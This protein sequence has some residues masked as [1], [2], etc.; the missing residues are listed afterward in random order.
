MSLSG[1]ASILPPHALPSEL[2]LLDKVVYLVIAIAAYLLWRAWKFSLKP[3][4]YPK[5]PRD[6]PYWI[7]YLGHVRTFVTNGQKLFRDGAEYLGPDLEPF[8]LTLAGNKLYVFTSAEDVS[9]AY[10]RIDSFTFDKAVADLTATFGVSH[11]GLAKAYEKPK[12]TGHDSMTI[13]GYSNVK[14]K[15]LAHLNSDY[16]KLQL[17]PG[18]QYDQLAHR[19]SILLNDWVT[20]EHLR[21]PMIQAASTKGYKISAY[22]WSQHVLLNVA[23]R[24]MYGD[25]L[26]DA[27]N[28]KLWYKM[29]GSKPTKDA[30]ERLVQTFEKY[31]RLPEERRP[32]TAPIIKYFH[33]T[34]E[35]KGLSEHDT[36]TIISMVYFV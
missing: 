28:W 2:H 31:L 6:L 36:A 25:E 27:D 24:A 3:V 32:N 34:T 7:P 33:R 20:A 16:Y 9:F 14:A 4:L 22:L 15:C 19:F 5:Q 35:A 30:K 1:L 8:T 17:H 21:G 13:A 11:S 29:P 18:E 23:S 10:K 26:V 12:D